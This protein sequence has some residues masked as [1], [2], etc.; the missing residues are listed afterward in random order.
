MTHEP[1]EHHDDSL[2]TV[3][4]GMMATPLN[5]VMGCAVHSIMLVGRG[6]TTLELKADF[7]RPPGDRTG[8]MTANRHAR[9]VGRQAAETRVVAVAGR[10]PITTSTTYP[11]FD[12]PV[13]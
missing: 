11:V 8:V 7:V 4:G 2:G 6:Y 10:L 3:P 12:V 1:G 5:G 13:E 9:H